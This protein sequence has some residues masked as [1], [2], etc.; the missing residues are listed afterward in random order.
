[1]PRYL[2][3]FLFA[4]A[5]LFAAPADAQQ[6]GQRSGGAAPAGTINGTVVDADTEGPIPT[7]SVAVWRVPP[8]DSDRDTTLVT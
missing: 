1:M 6:R 4:A 2:F 7:A 3:V 5:F 8:P